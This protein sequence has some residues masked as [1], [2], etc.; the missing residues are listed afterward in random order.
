MALELAYSKEPQSLQWE[1]EERVTWELTNAWRLIISLLH[2]RDQGFL[3]ESALKEYGEFVSSPLKTRSNSDGE[4]YLI[5]AAHAWRWAE[6]LRRL[7]VKTKTPP[8]PAAV[9]DIAEI[10]RLVETHLVDLKV[11]GWRP[12]EEADVHNRLEGVLG[13]VFPDMERKPVIGKPIKNYIPDTGIP[14]KRTLIEY[15]YITDAAEGKRVLDEILTDISAYTSE[16]YDHFLFVVYETDR[17]FPEKNG[18]TIS[19]PTTL[20]STCRLS[21]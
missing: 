17:V 15:K 11:F 10:I 6:V 13:C 21:S 8:L 5:S 7:Y 2:K 16:R 4:P 1:T 20:A 12:T 14:S 3:A 18:P 19:L 9:R